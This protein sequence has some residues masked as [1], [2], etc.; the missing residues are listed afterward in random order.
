M[1]PIFCLLSAA[2][3]GVMAVLAKLAYD[4]DVT[5]ETL[6]VLRFGLAGL[7]LGAVAW[8]RGAF[9]GLGR[10]AVVTG[11]AMGA[12]GYAAQAGLYFG[13]LTRVDA[14]QVALVFCTYPLL[15]MVTGVLLGRERPSVRRAAAL[16]TAM[17]GI[18]LVLGGAAAGTVDALG[19][20]LALGS[21]VVY[22]AYI[23]VG[24]RVT[25]GTSPVPL[26][27][28]VC[29]GAF[30]TFLLSVLVR[31]GSDL[32]LSAP[33][34]GW[35]GAL[36]LV[37]TV[38]AILLFF[39]GL[40]RVGPTVASLLGLVEPV[41]TVTAAAVVFGE[42]LTP[43]QVLGGVVVL[44][45]VAVVQWPSRRPEQRAGQRP[46]RAATGGPTAREVQTAPARATGRTSSRCSTPG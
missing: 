16:V 30:A 21:A 26:T 18:G 9:R 4:A 42:D 12:V 7:L 19:A 40:A 34:W 41:V 37:S 43:R 11:L 20:A 38:G 2:G 35:V 15:V 44:A 13:A 3:F 27:A 1:G 33:A 39:A 22:T 10:R 25:A 28:L 8:A 45:S 23:L 36:V 14:S 46:E 32:R 29:V 17:T 24:D 5:L 31:G 6:L